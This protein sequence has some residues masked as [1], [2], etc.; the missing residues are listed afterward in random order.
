MASKVWVRA[1]T[2]TAASALSLSTLW[3]QSKG[4]TTTAPTT[5]NTGTT[6]TTGTRTNTPSTT[7]P[8]TQPTAMP[9]PM[10]VSG[11]VMLEDGT[12][13]TESVIIETVC[14]GV[15]HGQGY[16]DSKG[17]FSV[18]L[19]GRNT[20]IPDASEFGN[21]NGIS[22]GTTGGLGSTL[23][24]NGLSSSTQSNEEKYRGCDIQAKLVGFRSQTIP[25]AG[26]RSMDDPNIGTILLHRNAAAEEGQTVS[27]ISLAAPKDAKKAYDKGI[28]SLK[29]KKWGDAQTNFEKAVE[30]YP[31]YAA[32]WYELGLLRLDQGQPD[33]A[34][35]YFDTALQH[36]PKFIKPYLQ[37]ELMAF[38]AQ[39]WSEL[40][41]V[42]ER[43]IR[44]DAFDYPQAHFFRA[45]AEFN[46][47]DLEEAEK[48]IR[49]AEKLDTRHLIPKISHLL[50]VILA[51]KKDY[52][53]AAERFR[54]YLK[55]A[56]DAE[57]APKV[58]A[59]L[60]DTEKKIT[61]AAK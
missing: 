13:P 6:S 7:T 46:Q 49:E 41:E 58:R 56:P 8:T 3:A 31:K 26:R 47:Q 38:Q 39:R 37:I 42:T 25:L 1:I 10:Y 40:A 19:G 11:R 4:G 30:A 51:Y 14:N 18:E 34:R 9:T 16:T 20:I 29:K 35:K 17:Y 44:L 48:S 36:D 53:A 43:I 28:D 15:S 55:Y 32:A 52:P 45:V 61:A 24:S 50:A 59:Q 54:A 22:S 12:P 27:M 5:G 23:A 21:Y 2:V 57:D 33:M 60:E